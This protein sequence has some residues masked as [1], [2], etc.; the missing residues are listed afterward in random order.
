MT[1]SI[2]ISKGTGTFIKGDRVKWCDGLYGVVLGVWCNFVMIETDDG[3]TRMASEEN[4][5]LLR[6]LH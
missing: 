4:I 3:I 2:P 1:I 6:R 5:K